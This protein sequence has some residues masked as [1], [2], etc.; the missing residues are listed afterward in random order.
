MILLPFAQM[1]R[2]EKLMVLEA[3]WEDLTRNETEFESPAWHKEALSA[4]EERVK[5]GTEP[6][7]DWDLASSTLH[8][9]GRRAIAVCPIFRDGHRGCLMNMAGC[10]PLA[11]WK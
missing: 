4:T 6:F 1:S 3:L 5:S 10:A 11:P 2:S 9:P 8:A 7:V